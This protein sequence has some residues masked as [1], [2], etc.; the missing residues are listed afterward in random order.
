M[1][2]SRMD[3]TT[4]PYGDG[5]GDGRGPVAGR[6][7]WLKDAALRM[8]AAAG[9]AALVV[10][11]LTPV[12][13][14]RPAGDAPGRPHDPAGRDSSEAFWLRYRLPHAVDRLPGLSPFGDGAVGF[15]G[16]AAAPGLVA[17][18]SGW[19]DLARPAV[20]ASLPPGLRRREEVTLPAGRG[21][22]AEGLNLVQVRASAFR[23]GGA[24][25]ERLLAAHGRVLALAP[26][27]GYI[28]DVAGR[29]AAEALA[30]EPFIE[31]AS[32]Y[33]PAFKIDPN[34][35]RTPFIEEKRAK[36]PILR[37]QVLAWQA[38]DTA[39]RRDL[40][41]AL[42]RMTSP[43]TVRIEQDD[44]LLLVEAKA[45]LVAAIA[46]LPGV[47][48]V[49][50]ETE[51]M[52]SNAEAPS[53][54]MVGSVEDT[55]GARPYQD[56]GLDGGGI[57]TNGDGTRVNDGTDTVPPQIVAVTD[58]GLSLDTPSFSQTATQTTTITAPIGAKHRKVH[59][60]QSVADS[61]DDC[62][63]I[64]SGSGSHGNVVAS[65]I[66]AWPSALGVYATKTTLP[67]NPVVTGIA[68][69]GVA[70]GARIIMQDAAAASRCTIDELIEQGGNIT[71]GNLT[72]R[73]TAARD[74]GNNVHLHVMPFG[75]PNFDNILD[76]PQ[77]GGYSVEANQLDTFLVNNRDYMVF[78]PIGNHGTNPKNLTQRRIPD[79]FDGTSLDNDPNFPSLNQIAPPATAKNVVS[80]GSHRTDMQTFA[81]SFNEEEVSSP[82][83]SRGPATNASLRMAP[84]VVSVGEDFSGVFGA[85]GVGG[86]AA[87]RSRDN[88]SL[89]P[90]DAQ[91]DELNF[92]TSY[93]A[94]YAGGAA[95]IVRDYFEQGFYP[96]GTR[97][98]GD[99]QP[100]V[101]GALV[102]AALVASANFLEENGTAQYPTLSDRSIAQAR[103][104][105]LG[106]ISG[107]N[108]GVLGN[109]EQGYGRVQLSNVLPIPNWPTA[110][111][112][113]APDTVEYPAAGLL[114]W[115][116]IATGEPP[117]SNTTTLV[118]HT[119]TVS[120]PETIAVAGGARAVT[121]G[122]LRVALAW[123]DPPSTTL[124]DGSLINDL[125][126]E[127]ESPG[128]DGDLATTADN[129]IYD[130]NVY[131]LGSGPRAGQWSAPRLGPDL[132][133]VR[134]PVEAVHVPSDLN[135][136]GNPADSRLYTGTWR[137]RV[138]RGA[139][140]A[141]PGSITRL[142][143]PS[144]DANGNFRL[145][146]GED[147]DADGLLDAGG[148]PFALVVA[149]PVLGSGTQTWAGQPHNLP[150]S[151][152]HLDQPTYGCADDL[153]VDIFDPDGTVAGLA[154]AVTLTV[155][156]AL[157]NVLDTEQGFA[158]SETPAGSHGFASARVPV[159]NAS[160]MPVPN[161]GLLE[162]DTGQFIVAD[163]ADTPVPGQARATVSCNPN[164]FAG[165]LQIRDGADG[166]A[167]FSGGCDGDQFPDAGENLTY[168]IALL[169]ANR[170]DDYTEVV[171]TLVPS[172]LGAAA[173]QVL[174]SPKTIG[175]LPGGQVAGIS[176][177][178]KINATT[179]NALPIAS[180]V[181]TLTLTLDSSARSK[182]IGR[183]SFAFTY[184]LNSDKETFH[185]ST[186]Y[187]AGGREIRDLN[188]N[189]QIDRADQIDPFTGIQVPDE[190]LVFS[191]LW[192]TDGGLVRNTL[193]EDLNSN[194]VRDTGETDVIPNNTLDKGILASAAG[195]SAGDKVPFSFDGNNGG[196]GA[197]RHPNSEI[198]NTGVQV[199][200]EYHG[201]GLC[202]F[203]TANP[204]SDGSPLF[205]NDQA[206]IWHTGDGDTFTPDEF[207]AGCDNYYMPSNP[208]TPAQAE[209]LFDML[210]SPIVAKVHQTVD[211]RGFPYTVEF[212][213]L[214]MNFN[215]QT[216]DAY[217]GGQI[218]LDSDID[219]D[220]RNCLL[221]QVF[222]PRFG[223]AYYGVARFNTYENGVDPAGAGEVRQRTFGPRVDP[224]NSINASGFVSGDESGFSGF[225]S[226]SN[227]NSTSPIP[228]AV[229]DLLPYPVPGG[230]LPLASD[231][232]PAL[233]NVRGPTR[234]FELSLVDYQDSY[235]F[236]PTGPGAYE[237][238]GFFN[239]GPTGN[240]WM[241][242]I[243]FF[244]IESAGGG[245]DY[246]LAIDD[247][248]LEWDESHPLDES[249]FV[250]AHTPACQRFGQPG[251]PAGQQCATLVVD[252]TS[253]YECDEALDVT[254]NDPKKA[255]QGSV[256][257]QAASDSDGTPFFASNGNGI[258][259]VK[260][261][262]LP[263]V[264]PGV[265]RG[266]LTVTSQFNNAAT[267]FVTPARDQSISIY[268]NDPLCDADG[269]AAVAESV[270]DNID[271]DNIAA[272]ADKCP[273][274][275]DPA[276]ADADGDGR[277]DLCDNCPGLANA[278]QN[279]LDA[280]GV[281][282]ACDF[283]D[284]DFD[285]VPNEV[286]NCPDVYNPSQAVG[287]LPGRGTACDQTSDRDADGVADRNDNCVRTPNATQVN[288]DTDLLGNA[289]DGDC[290][291][292]AT[293]TAATGS[294]QRTSATVC[295]TNANCPTTGTCSIT[296]STICTN[297][298]QC[299]NGETCTGIAQETCMKTTVT[300]SGT[301]STALDDYDNDRVP[302][303]AD[304]CPTMYNAAVIP[305]TYQQAD[306]DRDGLGDVCDPSGSLDDDGDGAPDDLV[307]YNVA[308]AC[309]ALP[310]AKL[311]VR[312]VRA[313]DVDGDHDIWID[314]GEKGR[315]FV[316]ILN[317]GTTDLTNVTF[318]LNSA[319]PD[320]ACITV[321]SI[322]RT[323]FPAGQSLVLG[324]IG[325]DK[326]AGTA[327]DTGDYFEV[328][329]KSTLQS[330]TGSN[331]ARLEFLLTLTSSETLGT[332]AAIPITLLADLDLPSGATQVKVLG[333][334]GLPNTA[335]DGR[336]VE[337]FE[338][339]RDG[340]AGIRI[341]TKPIGT[342]SAKNDTIGV[343]VGTGTLGSSQLLKAVAC[344][345]FNVPPLDPGCKIDPD[346]DM[347]WHIHCPA[348]TCQ[349]NAAQTTPANGALAHSGANSLH[350]GVHTNAA[351][352]TGD[353]THFRQIAAFMTNP[354]NLAI[355]PDPGDLQLSFFHIAD[356]VTISDLNRLG[357]R[358][359]SHGPPTGAARS[360]NDEEA[361][362]YGDVQIQ[363]DT[364]PSTS[365]D[366]WGFWD[367]LVPYENV[368]DH[369]PQV[370]SRFGTAITYCNLTPSDTGAGAPAPHGARETMCWPQGIWASCGWP[371]DQTTTLGCPGP[372]SPGTTGN[373]NW[374]QTKFD[375]ALYQGQRV[376]I[377]WIGQAWEFNNAASSYQELGGT[378]ADLDTDDGWW[379]DD[380]V[381]TGAIQSQI[382][383]NPD[384]KAPLAG[385]CPAACN[386]AVGDGGTTPV[387]A[388]HD[389]DGDGIVERGER[390]VLDASASMLP[391][392]C[393]NGVA[394]FRFERDGV[395]VQDW[396]TNSLYLDG[397]LK[398][399]T[400]KVKVRCSANVACV[401]ATGATTQALVYTGDGNDIFLTMSHVNPTTAALTWTARPQLTSVDG[402]D[403][404]RGFVD[405]YNGDPSL[406]T[407]VCLASNVPQAAVGSVISVSDAA[408]PAA[409]R[410]TYYY[411]VGHNPRA[412]GFD[413]LGRK[414]TGVIRI[415]PVACP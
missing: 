65:A 206:G 285:G 132:A 42:G 308:V 110:I 340:Q 290:T 345:G 7:G 233:N 385:A 287:T 137:V 16:P 352:R 207:S 375:L 87:F 163:Y 326:M 62:D 133:D 224:D 183:Q 166:A 47:E 151:I 60:I 28:V 91:L 117:I 408:I 357:R 11:S 235:V 201:S 55:L 70:R 228:T 269:D 297:N 191:T 367:K 15:T 361:F 373:G 186:D 377:R 12:R 282:D 257:V 38:L 169:N 97:R 54:V 36:S 204:D 270:F 198:G 347:D 202:G 279:D 226:D 31:A 399:A 53:V 188:R 386:P 265:F 135:G 280:D 329:A 83:A 5:A 68:L 175:R 141:V 149:G 346:N 254:V 248:V 251:Q 193:G 325:A 274:V 358:A 413:A 247:P 99:R 128:P 262:T 103:A 362:D 363:V 167:L 85:P 310:L 338:T 63:G 334:D 180:R 100:A 108:V 410:G 138:K 299:P 146:P 398:D 76:N 351:S 392:G 181:A 283:D 382:T 51:M 404:F 272:A 259:P 378:W 263:E 176:F 112:I 96:S 8:V 223:G 17:T 156:D 20:I 52:L 199:I 164:L 411:L 46:A 316:E 372:G 301:C 296:S 10:L 307:R 396:S 30:R 250:P 80:V 275:Y 241:F 162:T 409:P 328:V 66:A 109:M 189:L 376:R 182:V 59:A 264:S 359:A 245:S 253:L 205:Q 113:G 397:P 313:G 219:S 79:L 249:Q 384:L 39:A 122:A 393:S 295:T 227:L 123:P 336:I 121:R 170:G 25:L 312:Q 353:T 331:P 165:V 41:D 190:D 390:V 246:G 349:A 239:P 317:A 3:G 104:G 401:S 34:L 320:V 67:H 318:N 33:H 380:I 407:L 173:I 21:G 88:D 332:M 403:V 93:A 177:S 210:E 337:N 355:F 369:V 184:A 225:T 278:S 150:Q 140:G 364:D 44:R 343:V 1:E 45:D 90:I 57:D 322:R 356:M 383:P 229:P 288:S 48:A 341:D 242:G 114:V 391:G 211:A 95:A 260:T 153:V 271:G 77:N 215:H 240:R 115:D 131:V 23:N 394:Q 195:P 192:L 174:D 405:V 74:G 14:G 185:Y 365:V 315:I 194:G 148:Q 370:W 157:G 213:R 286:D 37:L 13:A 220:D 321:P 311:V 216:L 134:N 116:D 268:Y 81:G 118:E 160:P 289:C 136:D 86:V 105:N 292:A 102:K 26:E 366:A 84:I 49:A 232:T 212:Q 106:T 89:A 126:L 281:G 291:G 237:P 379:L 187:P 402:Y 75:V 144:E 92:G 158:F 24:D 406:A 344:G 9:L 258:L 2:R 18:A 255:G 43:G 244:V 130:G 32:P 319:D 82:W 381:I 350:W 152:T 330:T 73:M 389:T 387:L 415:A 159:R 360:L 155:Q 27:R 368:Y 298:G 342:P 238:G 284:V 129:L 120:A 277:G 303:D 323:T 98:A 209:F 171:A 72:T 214:A 306:A 208:A 19:I 94:A 371:Y 203:Q 234:N 58:N 276:Q 273:A 414:S 324:S 4:P 127:V 395:V 267:V 261:F 142:D 56:I 22:L 29:G 300:N 69:D 294:C 314:A 178:L 124:S 168:T 412:G 179:L 302:D 61:G 35:G 309:R 335:D 354:I 125:D 243:G 197:F 221:C 50:E 154:T 101:S 256:T 374:I 172:G 196:F 400:Y 230:P 333:P 6:P 139:G 119:F 78:S 64:L 293:A 304:N 222:Y 388:L 217:A 327:D 236:F 266:S 252:R 231:G 348:G 218:N 40:R 111:P 107:T 305:N 143:G 145:D 71:P 147:L 339:E 161:N 200:W